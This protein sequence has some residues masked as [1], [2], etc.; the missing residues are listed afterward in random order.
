M[1]VELLLQRDFVGIHSTLNT[2]WAVATK[3]LCWHPFYIEHWLSCCYKE[4]LLASILHWTLVELLL[5]R[6]FVG[7]HSALNTGWAVATKR[8]CWH[9]STL[10][11]GWAVATKRLC[12]HPFYIEHWLSCCYK[13]TLLASIL[14]WTLVELLLQRHFVGIHSALNTGWALATNRLCWHHST[15]NTGW[16]VATKSLWWHPFYIEHW[17]SCCYKETLLASILHWPLVELL[18]HRDFVGIH[19]TL[20][21]GWAVATKRLWWHP[22]YI[23][24]WLSCCYKETLLASIL[25]WPLVELLLHRDFVGI[26]S[27]LNTGWAVATKSLWWHPFY[28]EHWLSCCY[29]ETLLASILHW[30]LVELL[31]HRDFVGIH[32]TL[33]TGWAVAT[34]R[35]C[36]HH[37]TLKTGWAVA[38]KRLC[39]HHST[40]NTGW[41]VATKSLWWHPFYIEHWLSCCYKETLLASILHWP[42]V[43]LLLH[44]DFVGIH[45]TLNTGWAVATKRLCR[46][47]FYI[48][49]WLSCCY[50]ETMLASIPHWTLVELLVQRDFV[51]IHSTLNTGWAV[52]TKSLCWHHSILNTSW[53]VAIKRLCRH[54]FYIEHWLSCC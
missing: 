13:E 47:P 12:W 5:Q 11:T 53:A 35:L 43:E 23:E 44:R 18:L 26:H 6:D 33:N 46:H 48:E 37:S 45:S 31:L 28:I 38:T 30:P 24:H 39:W 27:T 3:R 32:S 17:L 7:I 42:L 49:Y 54:P 19:S 21:T 22:F 51:G 34:K 29:K 50:K 15:L 36:W 4:T 9:H 8:L 10:N 14:H 40:L 16:A 1:L 20:N 52:V 2:G 25:H 41:G